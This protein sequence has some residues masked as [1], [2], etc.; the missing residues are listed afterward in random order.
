MSFDNLME[1]LFG[2]WLVNAGLMIAL[3]CVARAA[4]NASIVDVGWSA[5][6]GLTA[7]FFAVTTPCHAARCWLAAAML[8]LWS[9]RLATH[10]FFDRVWQHKEEGR[11]QTLRNRWGSRAEAYFFVFF[12]IQAILAWL[13]AL[14]ALA[15]MRTDRPTFD[16][17]DLIGV[18]LWAISI[19]GESLADGQLKR[20]RAVANHRGLTCR[21]GLWRYSRHPNYFF[22]WLHWWAY[23]LLSYGSPV[24]WA[25]VLAPCSCCS[26]SSA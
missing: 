25:T 20:F 23:V 5:G 8:G 12:Q 9:L 18:G 11:Y 7:L 4:G 10:L 1:Q 3:W 19:A 14:P 17:L 26:F 13:F 15:T 24:W 16:R 21:D 22:E 2:A 6:V